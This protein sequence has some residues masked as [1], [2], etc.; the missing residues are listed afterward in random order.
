MGKAGFIAMKISATFASIGTSSFYLHPAEAVHGD[1]GRFSKNDLVL[2]LSNSGETPEVLRML[3][4]IKSVGCS[5]LS[6]TSD[7]TSTLAAQSDIVLAYGAHREAEPLAVA[8]TVTTTLM[9]ALGDALAM[10]VAHERKIT[11]ETFARYHP[12]GSLGRSLTLISKVMRHGERHCL[13]SDRQSVRE[14]IQV[15]FE[16]PGRPGAATVVDSTGALAGILTD[17]DIRRRIARDSNYLERPVSEVMSKA[18]KTVLADKLV[19]EALRIM[20]DHAFDELI[21]VDECGRPVGQID[22]QDIISLA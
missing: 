16:T 18:P 19:E 13:V 7:K 2:I 5:L 14:V 22:V 21:V 6:I 20:R 11:P 15:M 1:L 8:P 4:Y 9:L 10:A 17:G 12:G 3:P